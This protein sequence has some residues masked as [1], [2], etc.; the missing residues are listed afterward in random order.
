MRISKIII[1]IGT[2]PERGMSLRG[3]LLKVFNIKGCLILRVMLLRG[4]LVGY[5]HIWDLS[6]NYWVRISKIIIKF[7]TF[8]ETTGCGSLPTQGLKALSP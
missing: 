8:L 5:L 1:K 2:F 6:R 3:I 7:G 4:V